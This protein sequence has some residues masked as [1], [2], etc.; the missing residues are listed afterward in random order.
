[1][2]SPVNIEID[3]NNDSS[4]YIFDIVFECRARYVDLLSEEE[5]KDFGSFHTGMIELDS[6]NMTQLVSANLSV[7]Q[8]AE[9]V[10]KNYT[11]RFVYPQDVLKM[12]EYTENHLNR[13]M[14][15]LSQMSLNG[16][17]APLDDL[18]KLDNFC[19][20]VYEQ[21]KFY[22]K[23]KLDSLQQKYGSTR[24]FDYV[25]DILNSAPTNK[26]SKLK[27][28][29]AKHR[30]GYSELFYDMKMKKDSTNFNINQIRLNG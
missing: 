16:E 24:S 11:L 25:M 4:V 17:G 27:E 15:K 1:M 3:P 23:P 8:M 12:Y 14:A 29:A 13:W 19:S 22:D 6:H 20:M 26:E 9:H 5:L 28:T 21:A 18:I 10:S 30:R 2:G 7:A